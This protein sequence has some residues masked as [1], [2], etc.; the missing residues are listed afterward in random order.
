MEWSG[1]HEGWFG[2]EG[3]GGV[4]GVGSGRE[5]GGGG[6]ELFFLA[7]VLSE[8]IYRIQLIIW[9][10]GYLDCLAFFGGRG[11]R[12]REG[13]GRGEKGERRVEGSSF[14]RSSRRVGGLSEQ[15]DVAVEVKKYILPVYC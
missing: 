14:V 1:D 3:V 10:D 11:E 7:F 15:K 5:E 6:L 4:G 9:V 2:L 8:L 13:R 12:K